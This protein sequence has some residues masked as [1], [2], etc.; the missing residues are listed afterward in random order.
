MEEREMNG[1]QVQF[2]SACPDCHSQWF[3][4]GPRGG[5]SHNIRCASCGS[6]FWFS[7]PFTPCRID[8][9]DDVFC[10]KLR[11]SLAEIT[12]GEA[13]QLVERLRSAEGSMS[14]S[15]AEEVARTLRIT[16]ERG[17]FIHL[18]DGFLYFAPTNSP[19]GAFAAHSLRA[20]ADELDRRNA[21]W[22]AQIDRY[23][24]ENPA[25]PVDISW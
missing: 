20:L 3:N 18:E 5:C 1:A 22:A 11:F 7:P 24:R 6:K 23:F 9:E 4:A 13:A 17:E 8:S 25:Q 2:E 14:A 12:T 16:E 19:Y 21:P 10:L 15:N